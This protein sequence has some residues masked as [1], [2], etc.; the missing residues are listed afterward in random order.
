MGVTTRWDDPAARVS[1][2]A[3]L[4]ASLLVLAA[5][6]GFV[7][8]GAAPALA[9]GALWD[10]LAGAPWRPLR[11]PP[12]FGLRHAWV[13]TLW[14]TGIALALAV[15]LGVGAA[16]F[17]SEV[18]PRALRGLIPPFLELLAGV[19]SVVYGF[20]GYVTLVAWSERVFGMATGESLLVAGL[21]LA[22]MVLPFVGSTSI[23]AFRAVPRDLRE[24]A[25]ALGVSRWH[26]VRRVLLPRAAPALYGAVALGFARAAGETLAV[27]ML[28]GN[29]TEP[30]RTPLDR[31]QP[32]TALI[33]TELGEAGVG[34]AKSHALMAAGLLL[35]VL[36]V[37]LNT[38]IWRLRG[39]VSGDAR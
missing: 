30:P 33:A 12:D 7:A 38:G 32:L 15:P 9:P 34:S 39:H 21:V 3:L 35:L 31:G 4:A 24:A 16:L 17:V 22:V 19:P 29:S 37:A 28:A 5:V 26:V 10:L 13:S 6:A 36:V 20:I 27:L 18:A 1:T 8:W 25:Y 2:F 23:E 11:E 14:V